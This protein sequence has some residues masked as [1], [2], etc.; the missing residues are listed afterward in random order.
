MFADAVRA[1][2]PHLSVVET[3][4]SASDA[5]SVDA[6]LAWRLEPEVVQRLPALRLVSSIGAGVEK[7]FSEALS[8]D[9]QVCRVIDPQVQRAMAQYCV[10]M[11]LFH[12][13]L[14]GRYIEQQPRRDWSRHPVPASEH[15]VGVL[16][17]GEVGAEIARQMAAV[18]FRVTGWSTRARPDL[19]F[20][21]VCG[22][23]GLQ[24]LLQQSQ[25]LVCALPS[26]PATR[27]LLNAQT[28]KLLPQGAYLINV[29]RGDLLEE[30]ALAELI[31]Q[32][33]LA[34]AALDV[35]QHEPLPAQDPLW[36]IPG[37]TITPHIAGQAMPQAVAAQFI[38]AV[39]AMRS[40]HPIPRTVDRHR[41]Y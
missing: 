28:L 26:T 21:T 25:I 3:I 27:G 22:E 2:A 34:G 9:V 8:P 17:I 30:G 19:P 4:Q 35:Q 24:A 16:G 31:G 6:V 10:A 41:Q 1:A 5:A 12:T 33:H 15:R 36:T 13:R 20:E 23:A 11:A 32:G 18:G 40:R 7:L 38:E 37:V 39:E 29:A 14:L